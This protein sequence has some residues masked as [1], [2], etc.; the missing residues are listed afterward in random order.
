MIA[1]ITSLVKRL[2]G[3][4][5]SVVSEVDG[6]GSSSRM[7]A[8][9]VALGSIGVLVAHVCIHHSLPEPGQLGGLSSLVAAG[10][11]A[12]AAN[13]F[14]GNSVPNT[15]NQPNQTYQPVQVYQPSSQLPII[16]APEGGH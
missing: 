7:V 14:T 9:I 12:Y 15:P 13:K 2:T 10:S 4:G 11:G 3:F 1:E 16:D 8:L 6:T 5:K